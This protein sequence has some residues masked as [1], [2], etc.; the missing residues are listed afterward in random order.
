MASEQSPNTIK[1]ENSYS[2]WQLEKYTEKNAQ[3]WYPT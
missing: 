3:N 1:L 2:H